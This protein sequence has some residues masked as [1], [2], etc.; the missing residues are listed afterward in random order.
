MNEAQSRLYAAEPTAARAEEILANEIDFVSSPEFSPSKTEVGKLKYRDIIGP[1]STGGAPEELPAHL[2]R[3]CDTL[4][5]SQEEEQTLFR[6][7][8]YLR[9]TANSLRTQLNPDAVDHY[10]VERIE[11][12][13]EEAGAIREHLLKANMRLVMSIVKKFITRQHSFDDLLSE[14]T[15]TLIQA[16]EK[17]DYMRGF[18][19]STYAYRSIVRAVYRMISTTQKE[20]EKVTYVADDWPF[21]SAV[22]SSSS[23]LDDQVWANLRNITSEML[24]RLDRR[25]RMIIRCRYALGSHRKVT[26]FQAIADKL[27]VSKERV[28]QLEQR[29]IGK[30]K[31]MAAEFEADDLFGAAMV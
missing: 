4:L 18:R 19:F 31:A 15:Y 28:R 22:G 11:S 13:L 30:L 14:G 21:E 27:G 3:M 5:L 24:D 12:L 16:V 9:F 7:M 23:S 2:R 25:E 8:N 6:E 26:T 10:L 20:E 1:K 29:A 17:F